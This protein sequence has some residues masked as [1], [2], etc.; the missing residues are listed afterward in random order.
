MGG[1]GKDSANVDSDSA[2]LEINAIMKD[3]KHKYNAAL[4]DGTDSKHKEAVAYR[5]H[6]YEIAYPGDDDI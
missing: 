5:D 1:L 2:K 3:S 6:L 4:F